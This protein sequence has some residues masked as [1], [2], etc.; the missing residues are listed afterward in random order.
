MLLPWKPGVDVIYS[1]QGYSSYLRS[2]R[3]QKTDN[4]WRQMTHYCTV[5]DPFAC[6]LVKVKFPTSPSIFSQHSEHLPPRGYFRCGGDHDPVLTCFIS[7][8][9]GMIDLELRCVG[10]RSNLANIGTITGPAW[11]KE[12]WCYRRSKYWY[13]LRIKSIVIKFSS[14]ES[15]NDSVSFDGSKCGSKFRS[16]GDIGPRVLSAGS[17]G[18]GSLCVTRSGFCGQCPCLGSLRI[19]CSGCSYGAYARG[20]GYQGP[21][22]GDQFPNVVVF[23]IVGVEAPSTGEECVSLGFHCAC[24]QGWAGAAVRIGTKGN[25]AGASSATA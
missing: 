8:E 11:R 9:L 13:V 17:K 25:C 24:S 19:V 5:G 2:V 16:N 10:I 20:L 6:L 4:R 3:V 23:R 7:R 18:S 15:P 12:F 1:P 21:G 22:F 14:S